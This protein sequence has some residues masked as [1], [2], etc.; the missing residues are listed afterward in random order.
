MK[1][2]H[3]CILTAILIVAC[4]STAPIVTGAILIDE[5]RTLGPGESQDFIF[6]IDTATQ[7]DPA[8]LINIG[9]S[10]DG[11]GIGVLVLTE[12]NFA[13]WEASEPYTAQFETETNG[14]DITVRLSLSGAYRLVIS[15]RAGSA[16]ATYGLLAEVFWTES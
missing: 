12:A 8:L 7:T 1:H 4:G 14:S 16:S 5:Q 3:V 11:S 13:L 2:T 9:T 6:T 10:S 15:N